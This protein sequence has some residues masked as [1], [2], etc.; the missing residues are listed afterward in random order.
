MGND[1]AGVELQELI[2]MVNVEIVNALRDI[3]QFLE[4]EIILTDVEN[5]NRK[6]SAIDH[7]RKKYPWLKKPRIYK[8]SK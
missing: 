2:K 1:S 4:E 5:F 3:L 8:R 7:I 6:T